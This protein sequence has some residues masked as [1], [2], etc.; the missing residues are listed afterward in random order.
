MADL[1]KYRIPGKDK[2]EQSGYF[3]EIKSIRYADG[4]FL[5]T[6][7]KDKLIEFVPSVISEGIPSF[8]TVEPYIAKK[9]EYLIEAQSF[10][11]SFEKHK[12]KKAIFSRIKKVPFDEKKINQFFDDLCESYPKAFVYL[13]SGELIGTWIGASPEILVHSFS[14]SGFTMAL[15]GTK[16]LSSLNVQWGDKEI[17]EQAYVT[18]FIQEKLLGI[19]IKDLDLIGPYDVQAGPVV[20]L[21]T[22]ISFDLNNKKV[23]DVIEKLHP[24]PAVSGLPQ[25]EA[26]ELINFREPHERQFYTGIIGLIQANATALYVNLRCCQI[27]KGAAY[28]YLGGGYTADS[29]PE[30]EWEETENKSKTLLDVMERI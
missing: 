6:F 11:N 18:S 20:H 23:V 30:L 25:K 4:F 22:D 24:T 15:A 13:V 8:D 28:L 19:G 7:L 17:Q 1:L 2:I 26:I 29:D 14:N 21:R 10:L 5:S 9:E 3:R 27:Q 12:I 16:P